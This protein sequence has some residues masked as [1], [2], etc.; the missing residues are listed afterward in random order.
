MEKG[1]CFVVVVVVV[2]PAG[3][4]QPNSS[5]CTV[6]QDESTASLFRRRLYLSSYIIIDHIIYVLSSYIV[7]KYCTVEGQR[8]ILAKS[9]ITLNIVIIVRVQQQTTHTNTYIYIYI[10]IGRNTQPAHV[11]E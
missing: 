11:N 6:S 1:R 4:T 8:I 2:V 5:Y 10:Y 9:F 3:A 7:V